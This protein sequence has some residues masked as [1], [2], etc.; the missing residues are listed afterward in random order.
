MQI[1]G[2]TQVLLQNLDIK[3]RWWSGEVEVRLWETGDPF[4]T[5]GS[6]VGIDTETELIT[7]TVKDPPLV[8]YGCFD[9][10]SSICWIAY[11][12]EA[13][14]LMQYVSTTST[15]QYYFNVGF[16]EMVIDNEDPDETLMGAVDAGRVR[17]MQIRY[18]LWLLATVG[19]IPEKGHSSLHDV[20]KRML[21]IELDK[22]EKDDADSHRLTF[23][24]YNEDGTLYRM[25]QKQAIY[26]AWDCIATWGLSVAVPEQVTEVEHTKGMITLAHI[27]R[28]GFQV[29]MRVWNAMDDQ[30]V[31]EMEEARE[32]LMSFGFPDPEKR[33]DSTEP[34]ET[35]FKTSVQQFCEVSGQP[36]IGNHLTMSKDRMRFLLTF[37][38]NYKDSPQD[39]D[40]LAQIIAYTLSDT[41]PDNKFSLNKKIK[42]VWLEVLENYELLAFDSNKRKI[43]PV[44]F[45]GAFLQ[46]IV[47]QWRLPEFSTSGVNFESAIEAA[48]QYMDDH[49]WLMESKSDKIGPKKFF[50]QYVRQ[51]LEKYPDLELDKSPK[52]KDPKL[53]KDDMWRL[54]DL[55]IKDDF[56]TAHTE[57]YHLRK[58]RNTYMNPKFITSDGRIRA[59]FQNLVRTTRTSC[60][61][62]NL[63]NLPSREPE[64]PIKNVFA[65]YDGMVLCATD[66]SFIELVSFAQTC[67]TRFGVSTMRDLINAGIDPHRWFAGVMEGKIGVDL[68]GKDDPKWVADLN[69][70][71]KANV[72]DKTR[73]KAKAGN[74]GFP[75]GMG[76]VKFY[77]NARS[78]GIYLTLDEAVHMREAWI[79]AFPEMKFHMKPEKAT[80]TGVLNRNIFGYHGAWHPVRD[81]EDD[82]EYDEEFEENANGKDDAFGYRAVL[83]C[84]QIRNRCSYCAACNVM[85]QGTT[86]VGVKVA[87]FDLVKAGYGERLVNLIHDEYVYCLYPDEL[88]IHIPVIERIMI[89]GMRK[90]ITDVKVKVETTVMWHWDK[91]A[92][93]FQDLQWSQ[94]GAPIIGEPPYVQKI[95]NI[96]E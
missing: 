82:F 91:E 19:D 29:D 77:K 81:D 94:D 33:N 11:W 73:K 35:L 44:A 60:R 52:T 12:N 41:T 56:L 27:M 38:Y 5:L 34:Q 15:R 42:A 86:A 69:A 55:D 54:E 87:G 6:S 95:L 51:M 71:L 68:E 20:S 26:L 46:D 67:Y 21:A 28:N 49:P 10:A 23:R 17:D 96:K 58:F 61:A 47:E 92:T 40:E 89:N 53:A 4:P 13:L 83:P 39:I 36:A 63:Q 93:V 66:Y 70:F 14:P 80:D 43:V 1:L 65:P 57:Y 31:R 45:I 90:I 2:K 84:G 62:P 88:K 64:H 32:R 24:R 16:D 8:V 78:Q 48:S 76:A 7:D 25:T 22:G 75:G 9:P 50:V 3:K 74:F 79:K 85:F 59:H 37:A 30:L 72:D 18:H